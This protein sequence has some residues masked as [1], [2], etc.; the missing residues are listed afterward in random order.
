MILAVMIQ[1]DERALIC[2]F[3]ETYH[4]FDYKSLGANRAATLAS[5]LS[6][7][8][9]IKR[10]I[11]GQKHTTQTLLLAAI[12]DGIHLMLWQKTKDG[13]RNVNRPA[14]ILE[15]L[16]SDD[17]EDVAMFDSIE[18]YEAARAQRMEN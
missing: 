4:V 18:A 10:A 5:G 1:K 15:E 16:C 3:A 12:A 8:S 7:D 6:P 14:S 2:D 11:S 17:K 9:R 13:A